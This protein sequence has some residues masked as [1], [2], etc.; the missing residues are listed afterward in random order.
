MLFLL[1]ELT[2]PN[3]ITGKRKYEVSKMAS[4]GLSRISGS[5]LATTSRSGVIKNGERAG[6]TWTIENA[7][8]LVAGQNVTV[9]QLPRRDEV[10]V[11]EH[12][13]TREIAKGELVDFLC[14]VSIYNGD[15]Q[16]RVLDLFP[17]DDP[18]YAPAL[19]AV[20]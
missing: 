20:A 1:A 13:N 4:V 11:F 16:F 2:T 10:G 9:V 18:A 7:N 15:L 8:V 17:V 3:H 5:V 12:L 19:T 6:Q 14:E